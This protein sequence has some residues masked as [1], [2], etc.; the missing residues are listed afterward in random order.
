VTLSLCAG[1]LVFNH[2]VMLT[3]VPGVDVCPVCR[4]AV[5]P[6]RGPRPRRYCSRACQAKA[7]RE[8]QAATAATSVASV[9][10]Q[11]AVARYAGISSRAV[12]DLLATAAQRTAEALSAQRTADESDLETLASAPVALTAR[13]RADTGAHH[14]DAGVS[15]PKRTVAHA[16]APA[17]QAPDTP[18]AS[19]D[20]S[21]ASA[22]PVA[23][24]TAARP[25][26]RRRLTQKKATAI[27][28]T[29]QLVKHPDHR[30]NNRRIVQAEDG[31]VLGY[32][33][34]SYGGTSR[35]G[36]DGWIGRTAD[37]LATSGGRQKTRQD[38]AVQVALAW[39]RVMTAKSS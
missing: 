31:T 6:T 36:R 1:T 22:Q 18:Q 26:A 17:A 8:R 29:A 3:E 34:P 24:P 20:D 15:D 38:A 12:A 9:D 7:Y 35:S 28:G 37:A 30:E 10:E 32:V 5:P 25:P 4:G 13:T 27:A 39:I 19:R 21:Q 16:A 33:D 11:A 23:A 14:A 2:H